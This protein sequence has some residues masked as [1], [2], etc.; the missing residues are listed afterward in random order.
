MHTYVKRCLSPILERARSAGSLRTDA[1]EDAIIDWLQGQMTWLT[2]C[3]DLE[4]AALTKL[5]ETF[6]VPSLF[7]SGARG[8]D[9]PEK[10]SAG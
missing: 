5:L 1:T 10:L 8:A 6:V 3:D 2:P 7:R 9:P 4:E